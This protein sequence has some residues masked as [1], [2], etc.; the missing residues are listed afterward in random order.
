MEEDRWRQIDRIFYDLIEQKPEQRAS[1]L[2]RLCAD[3]PSL[4]KD[5]E[6][7]IQAYERSGS[8]L[9]SPAP[10]SISG[11]LVG[12]TL[13]S[14]EVKTLIGSGG[15]GEV[16]RAWDSKLKRDVA[17]KVLPQKFSSDSERVARFEREAEILASLNH[18]HIAAIY[19]V[20]KIG[21]VQFLV[22]ELVDGETLAERMVRGPIPVDQALPIAKQ[23]AEALEAADERGIVHRDLKPANIK[24]TAQGT[25]KVLDFGLARMSETAT[26]TSQ[27]PTKPTV[28][29]PG[30]IMGTAA[31][32][33]PEQVNGKSANR[34]SDVWAF[35][36]VVY[37]M[38]VGRGAFDG[39][40]VSEVLA[41]VLKAEP[42]WVALPVETPEAVR[43]LLR[44]CLQKDVQQRLRDIG[45]AR[46]E[47]EEVL[48]R[49]GN[50]SQSPSRPAP[51]RL[52]LM[53]VFALGT[54]I[55]AVAIGLVLRPSAVVPETRIEISAFPTRTV[56]S[57]A[58]SP[59][60][61]KIVF[62]Y[63]SEGRSTLWVRSLD[64]GQANPIAGTESVVLSFHP[65]WSPDSQ[66]IGFFT[67]D[68]PDNKLKRVD[69]NTGSVQTL[70]LISN[71]LCC[72]SGAWNHDGTILV[73]DSVGSISRISASGGELK[74]ILRPGPE[75][76]GIWSPEFLP[77]GRHFIYYAEGSA[78]ARGV[79]VSDLGSMAPRRLLDADTAAVYAAS[80]HL[81]FIREEKLFA[82]KIDLALLSTTGDAFLVADKVAFLSSKAALSASAA[83][84]IVFRRGPHGIPGQFV[85]IDR[86]GQELKQVG[87]LFPNNNGW[88]MSPDSRTLAIGREDHGNADIWLL[89]MAKSTMSR[90]TSDS[91]V[92]ALPVW[93]PNG[94]CIVFNSNRSGAYDLFV[95]RVVGTGNEEL[96][97]K[98]P[99]NK[100]ATDFSPNGRYLLYGSGGKHRS[101]VFALPLDPNCK[102]NGEPVAVAESDFNEAPGQFSPDG[103]WVAYQSDQSGGFEIYVKPFPGTGPEKLISRGGGGQVRWRHDGKELF[104]IS[105]TGWL[106]A[107]SVRINGNTIEADAPLPLF[108]AHVVGLRPGNV[109]QY[110]VSP[111]GQRFLMNRELPFSD[112]ITLIL[113]WKAKP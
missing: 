9:D 17:I 47:L 105:T 104:Y 93:S 13:G 54:L 106:N 88:A 3:D 113:N 71:P 36:C 32:M 42:D 35:G 45:D 61:R 65:F 102:Q 18:P 67:W 21:G 109:Y 48:I 19:D 26:D 23:I 15:M 63:A 11:S 10:V 6:E 80:G 16:Y 25:V 20:E 43:R 74:V 97:R 73:G 29:A 7:L 85:W 107:V 28:S 14:F 59:D 64:T 50:L 39:E 70:A 34:M 27:V 58:I 87:A 103:K 108:D 77:D 5:V 33:S 37:E 38:L 46:I 40:T 81:L 96:L 51:N 90:F 44:R 8:F 56:P 2:D 79:Y 69:L 1:L 82:Q 111:D 98:T 112:P 22:L 62:E 83:G 55:A 78:A 89:D 75:Q 84:P 95:K 91:G 53:T 66:S 99:Y 92:D 49:P 72:L 60:G 12:R 57:L 100:W 76:T 110:V 86:S 24:I 4:K 101:D 94:Q 68:P 52:A 41:S 30:T 31:Y